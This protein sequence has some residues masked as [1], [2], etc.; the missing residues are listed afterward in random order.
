VEVPYLKFNRLNAMNS[1]AVGDGLCVSVLPDLYHSDY[2][3]V[4]GVVA[5]PEEGRLQLFKQT[6]YTP[7]TDGRRNDLHDRLLIT[8]SPDFADVL[9]NHQNPRSP[10][11]ERLAPYM[12]IM[13]RTLLLNQWDT[14]KRYGLDH[15]IAND[16]AGIFVK[17][18]SEGFGVR[19]RPHPDYTISQVQEARAK[20]KGMGFLYG[21]YIDVTD[22]PPLNEWWDEDRVSITA[23]GDLAEAWPG[24]YCP[25]TDQ[26]WVLARKTGQKMKELYPP[27]CVYLDVTTNRGTDAVDFEAGYP[28][29]GMAR[30]MV[31]GVG[32]SLV[33]TRKWYGSTVS[34]G[35]YRWMYAGLSDMDYAQARM[36]D[37]QPR[38]PLDFDLLKL[39]PFQIGTMMGYGPTCFLTDEEIKTLGTGTVPG[40]TVF[41]KY[42]AT[43]LAYGHMAMLGYGY[44]PPISRTIHYYAL[45]QGVQQE[46]LP[47]TVASIAYWD[48]A[49][50]LATSQ[51]L[52]SDAYRRGQVRVTYRGGLVVTANLNETEN[53]TVTQ[54]GATYV[55]PPY[56]W[57][58]T[59]EG[60]NTSEAR[61]AGD[62]SGPILAYSALVD[63]KRMDY[64]QCPEYVYLNG[65]ELPRR[66]GPLEVQGAAWLKR[67]GRG[68]LLIPC[69]KLGQ[70]DKDWRVDKNPPDRGTSLLI[71]DLPALGLKGARVTGLAEMGEAAAAQTETLADGRLKITASDEVRAYRIQ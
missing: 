28:G 35:I 66:V 59:K 53:W 69:G 65:G 27:D 30:A 37:G 51:A 42:I 58:I 49:K 36:S 60:P 68:W 19:W 18:Y 61:R 25:K 67:E 32:D 43:S 52:Q 17:S 2:S 3:N 62:V 1:V 45:M 55:L 33:E 26:M 23:T 14:L 38:L 7:L 63:G 48:G 47:D 54:A 8:A 9:P 46:Y 4:E 10:N 29:A 15:I 6:V 56:G 44:I 34:E 57:V 71:V 11:M 16:F 21:A 31:I 12:F 70:W 41:Y 64:V 24:S 50:F 22:Q 5:K 20:I 13:S 40:P 39:H